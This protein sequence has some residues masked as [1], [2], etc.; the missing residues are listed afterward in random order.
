M[1]HFRYIG[2]ENA[3]TRFHDGALRPIIGAQNVQVMRANRE[4]PEQSQGLSFTY[5]HAPMLCRW[6]KKLYLMYL[7]SPVHEHDGLSRVMLT[8][9]GNGFSWASPR[10][11]FPE[12]PVPQGVYRGKGADSL[13]PDAKT[14]AHHRMGFYLSPGGVLLAM[15]YHGVSPN[16]HIAPNSGWGMGRV[17]RRIFEDGSL[18]E[19]FVLRVNEKAG[20]KKEHFPYRFFEESEDRDFVAACRELL[21]DG[22]ATGAWWEEERLD[23]AFFPLKNI[24][25]PSF[26]PLPDGRVG[27]IGKMGLTAVSQD[28][29]GTWSDPERMDGLFTATGKCAM[30]K[31]GDG[32]YAIVYNPSPDGQHRWPL[33]AIVSE[34][35]YTYSHLACVCGEVPPMRYGGYLK[36]FG[37]QYVRGIMP[38]NDDSPDGYTW[39]AYSMNKEDIWVLRL[40]PRLEW[41][42]DR[43]VREVFSQ[44]S[45]PFP[46]RWHIYSPQWSRVGIEDGALT[47]RQS[48]A[49]DYAK[50][51]RVFQEGETACLRLLLSVQ[52]LE[53]G[54]MHIEVSDGKGMNAVRLLLR[55]DGQAALRGGGGQW[56]IAA[57]QNGDLLDIVIKIDCRKKRVSAS[58]NGTDSGD[59]MPI[60]PCRT[61]ERLTLR[62]GESRTGPTLETELKNIRLP[63]VPGG[64]ERGK[65]AVYRLYQVEISP[66]GFPQDQI[67]CD[68]KPASFH[69]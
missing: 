31:T 25:A 32:R 36:D 19:V 43:P 38:G 48:D 54:E 42:E 57:Y 66:T 29:G 27:V 41:R 5:N 46:E 6:Q 4:H 23:E 47:L 58:V 30:L 17:A 22:L 68:S 12:I 39:L 37:P 59:Y 2:E 7:T 50:A 63:D 18:G 61:V 65:E 26:C 16:I 28:H 10:L 20:W 56:P 55:R 40:P 24:K 14:V 34:D 8:E 15:T 21:S 11:L 33:A 45:G 62:T 67:A 53:N 60:S 1:A 52:G 35:G 49:W 51:I 9:S 3:D 64:G 44:M 13:P 69:Q